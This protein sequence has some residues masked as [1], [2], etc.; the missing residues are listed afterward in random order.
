MDGDTL[1]STTNGNDGIPFNVD[2]SSQGLVNQACWFNG[3]DSYIQLPRIIEGLSEVS[4]SVWVKRDVAMASGNP[5]VLT[6][7]GTAPWVVRI[8]QTSRGVFRFSVA[9]E[10]EQTVH[11]PAALDDEYEDTNWHHIV[12]TFDGTTAKLYVDGNLTGSA[13]LT[14][15]VQPNGGSELVVGS[16][17]ATGGGNWGPPW[18][19]QI[20]ELTIWSVALTAAEVQAMYQNP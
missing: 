6:Q 14:G 7:M 18:E 17:Q 10:L 3:V 19:G 16:D 13:P 15:I 9:N 5:Y 2:C 12:G 8:F 20:D 11:L 4:V 1:D